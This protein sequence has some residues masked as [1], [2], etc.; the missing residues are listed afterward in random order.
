[1]STP[2]P[3][4]AEGLT[5]TSYVVLGLLAVHG[6]MTPYDLKAQ[7]AR[8]VG[9][10][11]SFPHSQLYGEPARLVALGLVEEEREQTGRRRRRFSVTD[12]GRAA[13]AAWVGEPVATHPQIRDLAL[14]K[15]YLGGLVPPER[16]AALAADQERAHRDRLAVYEQIDG[17]LTALGAPARHGRATVRLGLAYERAAAQFW[18]E[19]GREWATEQAAPEPVEEPVEEAS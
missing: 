12:A 16:V 9:Y 14:L 19:I 18:A 5:P 1:M 13:V 3:T 7:V 8:S 10:F 17:A 6:P 4:R 11:W 15:L 2:A